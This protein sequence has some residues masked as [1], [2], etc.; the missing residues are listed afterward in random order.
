MGEAWYPLAVKRDSAWQQHGDGGSYKDDGYASR[1]V[2]HTTETTTVASGDPYYHISFKD[3]GSGVLITQ[4]RPLDRASRALFNGPDPVQTNRIAFCPN[5]VIIGYAKD[6][7]NLSD[8]MIQAISEFIV[9]CSPDGDGGWDVLPIFPLVFQGGEAYGESGVGRLT[10]DGWK[11]AVG[12]LGHQDVPDGNK[13]WDPGKLPTQK[14]IE[15]VEA[16]MATFSDVPETHPNYADIEYL[17]ETGITSGY[18]DGTFRP[19]EPVTRK[20]MAAFLRRALAGGVEH[21]GLRR[22]LNGVTFDE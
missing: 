6:S 15:A 13:H 19:D 8:Q 22:G 10:I 16:L 4:Y 7:P 5:I 14:F 20:Q 11:Q 2:I 21:V 3:E 18:P 1:G 9:W 17:A 12:W